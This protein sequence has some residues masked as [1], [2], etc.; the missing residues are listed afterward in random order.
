[1]NVGTD[2]LGTMANTLIF[3]YIGLRITLLMT[4]AGTSILSGSKIEIMNAETV[5]AEALRLLA[6]SVGLVLTIPITAFA[7]ASWDKI[8]G[9]LGFGG[10]S[11]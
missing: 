6:G 11:A 7:A 1:M 5:A 9:F 2:V 10:R 4:L 8:T 3:A